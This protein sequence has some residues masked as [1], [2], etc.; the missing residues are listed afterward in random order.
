MTTQTMRTRLMASSM[1]SGVALAAVS[2]TAAQAQTAAP[3]PAT[4]S[5]QELVVTG[6]RIPSKNLT[7]VSPVTTV[8]NQAIKLQ[9]T[10]NVEDLINNL[11]QAFA[12]FGVF[13]T[14][15]S[16]GT[17]TIDLR[18]LGNTRTLVLI[19]GKRANPGDP[20]VSAADIDMIPPALIDRV[21]VLTG[22][23][24][25]VYGSDA[26]AGVVNFIM[27][28]D[29]QGLQIDSEF[30]IGEHDNNSQQARAANA[31]SES[32][33]LPNTNLP[34]GSVWAG[35]RYTTT[36]TGGANTPDDKGN[37]EFYLGYTHISAVNQG[38]YDWSKC[39]LATNTSDNSQQ[40][41]LGSSNSATGRL[42]V[43]GGPGLAP[44]L[45]TFAILGTPVGGRLPPYSSALD[46]NFAPFQFLQRADERY[47]AGEFSHYEIAP[48]LDVY[49][50]FMFLDDHT[51]AQLGPSAAFAG[52]SFAIP[53]NDPLLSSAQANTICGPAAGV[54]GQS[55]EVYIG[56][57]NVEGGPRVADT[58]HTSY[59][60][61]FGAKGDLGSGWTYDFSLQYGRTVLTD[62]N[63]GGLLTSHIANALNVIP[64]PNGPVCASGGSCVPWNIWSPGGVTPAALS[65][66][67]GTSEDSGFVSQQVVNGNITGDLGQYGIK[68]PW[69]SDGVG[70][71]VGAEYRREYL[72]FTPDFTEQSGDVS[73]TGTTVPV[74]GSQSDKDI[75][76]EIRIP[77]IQNMPGFQ[78]L[79][80][81]GGYRY[82]D[83]TSGGGNNTYKAGVDWQIIP[84]LRLRASYE[85]AVRAPTVNELFSPIQTNL[86][87]GGDPCSGPTPSFTLAQCENTGV[88]P[89]EYGNI[90]KCI[91]GQCALLQGG[92]PDLTPEVGKTYS[93]GGVFTPTF[94]RGFSLS[95]DYFHI[96]VDN[97][98]TTIPAQLVLSGC[99]VQDIAVD[100]ASIQRSPI[101]FLGAIGTSFVKSTN[102]NAESLG[103]NGVDI[104]ADYRASLSDWHLGDYGSLDFNL[105]FTYVHSLTTSLVGNPTYNCAGLFG[106]TCGTPTP[107]FRHQLRVTWT[108]PWNLTLSAAWRY[109]SPTS[110]DFNSNQAV[111]A[112]SSPTGAPDTLPTDAHIPAFSYFDL[113]FQYKLRDRYTIRGGVNNVF[114]RTPP[115]IDTNS[116]GI[117]A[118]PFGNANT[119]PQIFDPL[120]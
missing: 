5:V 119:Y 87:G 20:L 59:N 113:S 50:Q 70:I 17:S 101:G 88:T 53:C 76:G 60:I 72:I 99:A 32:F 95:V 79:T 64:G 6:S 112:Q 31:V 25:A 26:V 117:S 27:K 66:I 1:I 41:C 63:T 109:L 103:T 78:D 118:P 39:S 62:I 14:N 110:L 75:F 80:F 105:T 19:N 15:A 71:S 8:N 74:Q 46:F 73:G 56:R 55:G 40:Y 106:V 2:V 84:D 30:S 58:T 3:A 11:P 38:T 37:V 42:N 16:S 115:I 9:G 92:N 68:S 51:V 43:V 13:E 49:S 23:A 91:S 54:A 114:D 111:L 97:A 104:N 67:G 28:K 65:Y 90:P 93:F 116:Y 85:R 100:C 29:F 52:T 102:V 34:S 48:W 86:F 47:T 108:T 77:I 4:T 10:T 24:S 81:E 33:G 96:V 45:P 82:S 44:G 12:D 69:A 89:A 18:G 21:E 22:G 83:Y 107:R 57:R 36:I 7:S 98:I 35:S 94:F 120:G 61:V